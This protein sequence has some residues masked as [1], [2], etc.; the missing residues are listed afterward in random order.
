M[1]NLNE[2]TK[3]ELIEYIS[4][5]KKQLKSEKYGLYWDKAIEKEDVV[6]KCEENIPILER[7]NNRTILNLNCDG[8]DN[9]LIEGDNFHALTILNMVKSESIDTIYIDPP[10]N[11]LNKDFIYNDKFVDLEDGFRHSKWL[12]FMNY[13]LNLAKTLLKDNGLFFISIDENEQANLKLLCDQIFGLKNFV[14]CFII[15]KTAQGANQS[16]TFKQQHEYCLLYVKNNFNG[17]NYETK[18]KIDLKKYKYID[19]KG[20]YAVTNSFDSINSPLSKNKSR[21]YTIYY[22]EKIQD[23]T[24]RDEYDKETGKFGDLDSSLIEKGYTPIRPGIRKGI[25]YPWNWERNRFLKDY[26]TDLVF[27]KNRKGQLNIYHKNRATGTVKDTTIKKFD[28]RQFGNQLLSDILGEKKFNYP[29]SL[30]M[31][32]WVI[33]KNKNK[34]AIVLDFFAGSGT[35]GQ[36]VMELNKEDGGHRKFILCTNNENNIC[37]EVTYPRLKTCIT[38]IR[39]NGSKYSDGLPGNNLVYY[40][41]AFIKDEKNTEQAKYSLVEKVDELLCIKEDIFSLVSRNEYSSHYKSNNNSRHMFIYND[42]FDDEKIKLFI[43]QIKNCVDYKVVYIY[44][45]DNQVDQTL[46]SGIE[47]IEV[48][49]I[50]EKIYEIYKEIVENIKR[51]G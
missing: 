16:V 13:R 2:C 44:S 29:K 34:N 28:T 18:D 26:K 6:K 1:R 49:P 47:N 43:D 30:D 5:L 3:Q 46:F 11:T 15:D 45:S 40:K 25:Q 35:T 21:G 50:P 8:E 12:S 51:G 33:S 38:G 32:K 19:E 41:T 42:Y 7:D 10:Y 17:I 24:I 20:R 27:T 23:A 39:E 36:A 14:C 48:K 9:V 37:E 4:E 31:M 22:N